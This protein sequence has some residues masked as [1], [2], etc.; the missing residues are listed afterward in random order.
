VTPVLY[1]DV[2][3]ILGILRESLP[4]YYDVNGVFLGILQPIPYIVMGESGIQNGISRT[5]FV[6]HVK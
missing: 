1:L 2:E 6:I 5:T 4:G 3:G